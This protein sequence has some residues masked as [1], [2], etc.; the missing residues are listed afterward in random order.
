MKIILKNVWYFIINTF[1]SVIICCNTIAI[2][3]NVDNVNIYKLKDDYITFSVYKTKEADSNKYYMLLNDIKNFID[4]HPNMF[5]A[6]T[7]DYYMQNAVYDGRIHS[8]NIDVEFVSAE[9]NYTIAGI[10]NEEVKTLISIM[11]DYTF[12]NYKIHLRSERFKECL[13]H[14]MNN[15]NF[16][17]ML[18][19]S[20]IACTAYARTIS[21]AVENQKR[22]IQ[23]LYLMGGNIRD[24]I[25]R[26]VI[27]CFFQMLS[28]FL[29]G[30]IISLDL[31]MFQ[32]SKRMIEATVIGIVLCLCYAF[33]I[34]IIAAWLRFRK[35]FK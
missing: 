3:V 33:A 32:Y 29:I 17:M 31:S 26:T 15:R 24:L 11:P 13:L 23:I 7:N 20:L 27:N 2:G 16:R 34:T 18:L 10:S 8:G 25:W 6:I 19:G 12:E 22:K 21:L 9:G 1:L 5:I 14:M 28:M 30:G 35:A 4:L